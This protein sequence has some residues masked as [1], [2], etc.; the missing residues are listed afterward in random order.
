M[1]IKYVTQLTLGLFKVEA[2]KVIISPQGDMNMSNSQT[3][4]EQFIKKIFFS[5][6]FDFF[7]MSRLPGKVKNFIFQK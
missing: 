6:K 3:H 5:K 4:F 1:V 7:S 2:R